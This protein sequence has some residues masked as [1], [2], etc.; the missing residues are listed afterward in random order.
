MHYY[1]GQT[2]AKIESGH[3]KQCTSNKKSR[4]ILIVVG[5]TVWRFT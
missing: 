2:A 1:W 4:A 3:F 5:T